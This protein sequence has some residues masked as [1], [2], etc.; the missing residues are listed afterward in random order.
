MNTLQDRKSSRGW[1]QLMTSLQDLALGYLCP[2]GHAPHCPRREHWHS[3][4]EWGALV[5]SMPHTTKYETF[6]WC[7]LCRRPHQ[8]PWSP[9]EVLKVSLFPCWET[10]GRSPTVTLNIHASRHAGQKQKALLTNFLHQIPVP[11]LFSIKYSFWQGSKPPVRNT[12]IHFSKYLPRVS[13]M[14]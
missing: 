5:D 11:K 4:M 10:Y 6:Y 1:E 9:V 8:G 3:G 13:V 14:A 12:W 2:K 7:L